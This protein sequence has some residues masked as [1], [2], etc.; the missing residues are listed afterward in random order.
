M[1]KMILAVPK[2][3][4]LN[5]LSPILTK[6]NIIPE[7]EFNEPESRKLMFKTSVNFL[8]IIRVRSFDVAT[9]VAFGAAHLGVVGDDVL[10][11]FNYDEV[12]NVLDLDIGKC[13]LSVAHKKDFFK[14]K[15]RNGHLKIAT[16]YKNTVTDYFAS[17][18]IRAECIK[19]NGAIELAPKLGICSTIVDLV[20]SGKTLKENNLVESEVLFK[21]SSKLVVNKIAFK[22]NNDKV[23]QVIKQIKKAISG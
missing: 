3:R 23:S 6:A 16:K 20:S 17:K 5:E 8:D 15:Q 2:G 12:N 1:K 14:K 10:K 18:G 11:E 21:I 19:L 7:K 22:L 4:I 9:F 13:K